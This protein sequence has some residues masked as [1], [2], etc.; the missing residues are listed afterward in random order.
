MD[1]KIIEKGKYKY[2]EQGEGSLVVLLHGLFGAL[3]NFEK[4]IEQFSKDHR[5]IIPMLPIYE[6]PLVNTGIGG[7][8]SFVHKFVTE[9]D[10]KDITF[11]GNSLG[12]HIALSFTLKYPEYVK[13]LILTGSSGLFENS[14]GGGFPKRGDYD[15]IKERTQYTF[16]SPETATK[17]LVDEVFEIVNN[18]AKVIRVIAL[19]KSAMRNNL[20]KELPKLNMPVSLIWGKDDN[21]TPAHVA[22]EFNKLIPNSEL[23]FIDKCGHAAMMEQ[24][25]EFNVLMDAFLQKIDKL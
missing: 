3:S 15:Y 9:L 22:E 13:A 23:H 18:R 25:E 20:A 10:L 16:Y 19:S 12:G 6:L 8:R 7:L 17:E 11:L 1:Y 2:I 24:P 21:I 4:V 5:V 14:L